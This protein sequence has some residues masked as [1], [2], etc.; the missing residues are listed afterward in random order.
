VLGIVWD[1]ACREL[2]G[3]LCRIVYFDEAWRASRA[4]IAGAGA[5][6]RCGIDAASA[7]DGDCDGGDVMGWWCSGG[8]RGLVSLV[9]PENGRVYVSYRNPSNLP[10]HAFEDMDRMLLVIMLFLPTSAH[11]LQQLAQ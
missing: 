10:L 5:R 11:W 2:F 3:M 6:T 9:V 8:V 4:G 1:M 7:R